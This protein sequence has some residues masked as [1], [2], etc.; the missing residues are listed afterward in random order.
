MSGTHKHRL[1]A[2]TASHG[3]EIRHSPLCPDPRQDL[4]GRLKSL[5]FWL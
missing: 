3:A 5:L 2:E 1:D 4:F